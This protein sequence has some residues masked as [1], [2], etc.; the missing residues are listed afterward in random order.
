[1]ISADLPLFFQF[2]YIRLHTGTEHQDDYANF[3][4]I[5]DKVSRCNNSENT[6]AENNSGKQCTYNLW[7]TEFS[8]QKPQ[9]FCDNRI[10]QRSSK[11]LY[12]SIFN[13]HPFYY[14]NI[15][16]YS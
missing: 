4:C 12:V 5:A 3:R 13:K 11:N 8:G 2:L 16:L 6:R 10:R 14:K 1:M 15:F 7:H 9:D